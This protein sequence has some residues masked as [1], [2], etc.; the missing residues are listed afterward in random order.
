MPAICNLNGTWQLPEDARIS[1]LDRG[2]LFG[3]GVYEVIPI[4]YGKAFTLA[5]HLARLNRSLDAINMSNPMTDAE[6]EQL[7]REAIERS[8]ESTAYLYLHVTRG[9]MAKRDYQYPK[10]P[11][12]T[13]LVMV[14]EAPILERKSIVPLNMITLEDFRW[15]RGQI[16]TISLIAAGYLKNEAI[17]RGADDAILIKDGWVT[18][19]TASNVFMGK[20][21]VLIT[22]PKS[23]HILHGITRD[24]VIELARKHDIEVQERNITP[25]EL[26]EADEIM[27][28]SSGNETWP[29]GKLNGHVIGNGQAGPLWKRIDEL[30]QQFKLEMK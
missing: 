4:Y 11:S 20:Q 30:F 29:V 12:P 18:E 10:E 27:I 21:G 25:E 22:P 6:W 15:S 9:V 16:K 19:A 17:A 14:Y 5:R 26:A 13:V 28:S 3:D 1:V 2:F 8:G 7:I 24:V 23:N